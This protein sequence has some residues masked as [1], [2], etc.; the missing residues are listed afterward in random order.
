MGT[1]Q[2]QSGRY[3]LEDEGIVP[4]AMALLFDTLTGNHTAS[5]T[6]TSTAAAPSSP[7]GGGERPITPAPSVSSSTDNTTGTRLRPPS[8][9][10][11]HHH[12]PPPPPSALP[13]NNNTRKF[14]VK[15]SFIEIYNEELN[16][17][18]NGSPVSERPPITIREDAKGHIYWTGVKEVPVHSME[19]VLL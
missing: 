17:L 1:A 7:P 14:S 5:S 16:D 18:L 2:H 3:N 10:S 4:R 11:M 15:V 13:N 8:R 9:I 19:D 12:H 6:S